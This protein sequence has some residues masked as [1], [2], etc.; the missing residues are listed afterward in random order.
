MQPG[1]VSLVHLGVVISNLEQVLVHGALEI[2]IVQLLRLNAIHGCFDRVDIAKGD[3]RVE[4]EKD[5][6]FC[7]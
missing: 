7:N 5:R 1:I 6:N 3:L 4:K 2:L